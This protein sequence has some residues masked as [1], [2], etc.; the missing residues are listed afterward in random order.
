MKLRQDVLRDLKMS[1]KPQNNLT[2]NQRKALK[3]LKTNNDIKIYPYDKGAGM[4]RINKT[5]ALK[6]IEEQ[7]GNTEII[8]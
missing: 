4:V 2:F 7:I 1:K 6:K 8:E 3:E 5:D